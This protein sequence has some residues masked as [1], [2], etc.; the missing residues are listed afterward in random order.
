M[1]DDEVDEVIARTDRR[2]LVSRR[3]TVDS[4]IGHVRSGGVLTRAR[5]QG[6]G[7]GWFAAAPVMDRDRGVV[8]ALAAS[9]AGTSPFTENQMGEVVKNAARLVTASL[10]KAVVEHADGSPSPDADPLARGRQRTPS[11]KGF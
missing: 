1:P 6:V 3:A 7:A 9:V 8:A 10:T 5:T 4:C 11:E 2:S